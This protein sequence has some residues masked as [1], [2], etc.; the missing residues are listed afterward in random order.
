MGGLGFG[1]KVERG[2]SGGVNDQLD[3]NPWKPGPSCLTLLAQSTA[4]LDEA[5]K[6]KSKISRR[7][8]YIYIAQ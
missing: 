8:S 6:V 7:K 3:R 4:C 5:S 2:A 1:S